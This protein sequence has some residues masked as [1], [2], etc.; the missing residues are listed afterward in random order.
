MRCRKDGSREIITG[1]TIGL[2]STEGDDLKALIAKAGTT[3]FGCV[4]G[5]VDAAGA[6]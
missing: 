4:E 5:I 1:I 6:Q 2:G 3:R